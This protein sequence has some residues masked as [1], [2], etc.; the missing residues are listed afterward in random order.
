MRGRREGGVHLWVKS[1]KEQVAR[2]RVCNSNRSPQS[3]QNY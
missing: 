2:V 3:G 1:A